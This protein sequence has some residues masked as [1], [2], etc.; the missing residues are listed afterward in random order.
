MIK[1]L[2][3]A[4]L[5]SLSL[6]ALLFVLTFALYRIITDSLRL[7]NESLEEVASTSEPNTEVEKY[8][9]AKKL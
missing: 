2:Q 6:L 7:R 1:I 4:I 8:T 9:F 5:F 3:T